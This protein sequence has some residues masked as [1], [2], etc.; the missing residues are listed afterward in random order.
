MCR[1]QVWGGGV[2]LGF[3]V[4]SSLGFSAF[5]LLGSFWYVKVFV[6]FSFL[7][8]TAYSLT[9]SYSRSTVTK[10]T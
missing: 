5:S 4:A 2:C 8:V 6:L 9:I 7:A 10:K 1:Q 3:V